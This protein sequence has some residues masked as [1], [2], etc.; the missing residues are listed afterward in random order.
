MTTPTPTPTA[1]AASTAYDRATDERAALVRVSGHLD[2]PAVAALCTQL[3]TATALRE[4]RF[5]MGMRQVR[6][7]RPTPLA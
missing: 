5:G 6:G 7:S 2:A 1:I 3:D 4:R